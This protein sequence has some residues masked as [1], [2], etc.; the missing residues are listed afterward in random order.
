MA[1]KSVDF[2]GAEIEQTIISALYRA[3]GNKES[4]STN[5]ILEQIHSTKPLALLKNEE[6]TYL[7]EWAKERTIPA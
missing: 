3:S 2:N 6:I 7:R 4:V 5:H 1:E